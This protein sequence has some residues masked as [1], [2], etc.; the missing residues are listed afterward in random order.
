MPI[1]YSPNM[2]LP[3][4]A[5]GTTA[6]PDY[7]TDVNSSLTVIDGHDHSPG[8]GVQINPDG[9]NINTTLTMNNNF[10]TN[11]GGLTLVAQASTPANGTVYQ[12][13]SGF[14]RYVDLNTG[15]NIQITNSSGVAGSPGS[16]ANL[17]SPASA[18][19]VSAASTFVWQSNTS[20]AAN[21]DFGSAILRNLSPNSTFALTLQPPTLSSN[22]SVTLPALPG[23]TSLMAMSSSGVISTPYSISGGIPGTAIAPGSITTTQ[24]AANTIVAGNIAAGTITGTEIATNV[25]LNG[26]VKVNSQAVVLSLFGSTDNL[27]IIGGATARAGNPSNA[28]P[29]SMEVQHGFTISYAATGHYTVAFS[30]AFAAQPIVTCTVNYGNVG[31]GPGAIVG[32]ISP[33]NISATGFE[34]WTL[35]GNGAG[36]NNFGVNFLVIG[37]T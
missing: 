21:M 18:S 10:L 37:P 30:S 31:S 11:I 29:P 9:L 8:S 22:Y 12:D 4:P 19:Y 34:F 26:D 13:S 33:F 16:I 23:S 25:N 15:T 5:V 3:V 1:N 2:G 35:A 6:G 27:S 7:A 28:S 20:I 36:A 32:L 17:T 14:L 24:I